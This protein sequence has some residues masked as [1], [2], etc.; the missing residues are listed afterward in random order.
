MDWNNRKLLIMEK[1]QR[2]EHRTLRVGQSPR[3]TMLG[4]CNAFSKRVARSTTRLRI[5]VSR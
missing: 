3:V 4:A 5:F 1:D 2:L